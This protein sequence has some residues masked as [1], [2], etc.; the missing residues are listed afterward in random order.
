VARKINVMLVEDH[1]LMFEGL[2]S[3]LSE[4]EDITVVG[5][6]TTVADAVSK[7][8]V[9]KPDLVLMDYRLPDGDG[10]Q[11]SERIRA[12]QP[13][14]AILFL[15]AESSESARVRAVEAGASGFVSKDARADALVDS[16]RR[17]A[18]GELLLEAATMSRLLEQ[19]RKAQ[20]TANQP[21]RLDHELTSR[22]TDVL[23]LMARGLDN[24]HIA[25]E[26]EM[27]AG[28]V[29]LEVRA[30][31][32]KLGANTRQQAVAVARKSGVVPE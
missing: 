10:A 2:S 13:E 5:V 8:S 22:E 11:A 17:A 32:S 9:L 4:Y 15:S 1:R 14:T 19:R 23:R 31:L 27:S 28:A 21:G 6:A 18:S 24:F 25:D 7:A 16:I 29:R 30:L 12:S 3:L 26:L 20:E